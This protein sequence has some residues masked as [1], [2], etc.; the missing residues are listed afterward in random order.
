MNITK[1]TKPMSI[2]TLKKL[3]VK[4]E[5]ALK[6]PPQKVLFLNNTSI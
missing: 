4:S 1:L 6:T 2:P 3:P 5:T